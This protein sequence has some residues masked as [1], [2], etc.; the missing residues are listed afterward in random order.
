MN[1]LEQIILDVISNCISV[2]NIAIETDLKNELG[3]DSSEMVEI[4]VALEKALNI[5]INNE[6]LKEINTIKDCYHSIER[7]LNA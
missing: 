6:A 4:T 3:V 5:S 7:C 1:E 2:E